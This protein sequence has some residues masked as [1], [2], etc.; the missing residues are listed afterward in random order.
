MRLIMMHETDARWEANQIPSAELFAN[1]GR[2]QEAVQ[3]SG[4]G[5]GGEGL[6]PTS[7][8]VRLNFR[9]GERNLRQ[10]PYAGPGRLPA[11]L[12]IARLK[13]IDEA[14]EWA[15]RLGRI[16]GDSEIDVRPVCE[17]WDLGL[18]PRP[19][20]L[21]ATRFMLLYKADGQPEAALAA[22]ARRP[23]MGKLI[24]EMSRAGVLLTAE[25]MQ[26]SEQALRLV[27]AGGRRSVTDGP[28]SEAKEVIAGYGMFEVPTMEQGIE[29]ATRFAGVVGD[30]SIDIRQLYPEQPA[31]AAAQAAS[32][33][34]I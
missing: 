16:V 7:F 11:G 30:V 33:R 29:W 31:P 5:L 28:F 19:Q 6:R 1:M 20:D 27:F 15:T 9:G 13:S 23:A 18:C 26:P 17:P 2:L 3:Q 21:E 4:V 22:A 14:V 8:G 32:T 25:T 24:D 10:G 12:L 34:R